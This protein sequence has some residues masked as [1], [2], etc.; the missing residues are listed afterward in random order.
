MVLGVLLLLLCRRCFTMPKPVRK[1]LPR[2]AHSDTSTAAA[3]SMK[4]GKANSAR[5]RVLHFLRASA[6]ATDEEMQDALSMNPSTQRPR[7]IELV[8][9]G[10]AHDSGRRRKTKSGS[11]AVVWTAVKRKRG[12]VRKSATTHK[13]KWKLHQG[14]CLKVMKDLPDECVHTTVTSPPY[15][16]LRDY[17]DEE[18]HGLESTLEE[19]CETQ[20]AVFEEVRRITRDDGTLWVNIGD[21]YV[22]GELVGQPWVLALALKQ[23][24]W[25]LRA[26]CIW[27]KPNPMPEPG[28]R[29]RPT[30]AHEYIFLFAKSSNYYYDE[31]AVKEP[32]AGTAHS[33]GRKI[34]LEGATDT[35]DQGRRG[36]SLGTS[37]GPGSATEIGGRNRRSVWSIPSGG[38]GKD[39]HFAAFPEALPEV[40]VKA[41]T[42]EKGCCESC[43]APLKRKME[44]TEL[45]KKLLGKGWHDHEDDLGRGQRKAA[46]A[47]TEAL[48]RTVGWEPTCTC[49]V[50]TAPCR[51]FD[52]YAGSG[53]TGQ[54]AL[55]LGRSFTGIELTE[56]WYQLARRFLA[57]GS[58]QGGQVTA[59]DLQARAETGQMS[60]LEKSLFD[61]D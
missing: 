7:R 10:K 49:D 55:R 59:E 56:K 37:G 42:S 53:T 48:W 5:K 52:P 19:W 23:A 46:P 29:R 11:K 61:L 1:S 25:V 13:P 3:K 8:E 57:A 34:K 54:V 38:R 24:G 43:G 47:T 9:Q 58:S 26:D 36:P 14:D 4:G 30:L 60:A 28:G 35:L 32:Q 16:G 18:Q 33:R 40:C 6:G 51:V 17:D 45:G 15:W 20:V 2:Q 41:A 12:P 27:H 31:E 21:N 22:N 39:G 50:G 44:K